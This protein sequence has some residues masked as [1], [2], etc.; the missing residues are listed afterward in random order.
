MGKPR[1]TMGTYIH[2]HFYIF[3]TKFADDPE[4]ISDESVTNKTFADNPELISKESVSNKTFADN[5]EL[6]SEESVLNKT[7][8]GMNGKLV[9]EKTLCDRLEE[10]KKKMQNQVTKVNYVIEISRQLFQSIEEII[11]QDVIIQTELGTLLKEIP[12]RSSESAPTRSS[13]YMRSTNK[14]KVILS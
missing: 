5:P 8:G 1:A 2:F 10:L 7:F 3:S 11:Q 4:L 13:N 12:Q 6:I 14:S 9:E